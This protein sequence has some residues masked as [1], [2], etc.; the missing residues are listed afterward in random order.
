MRPQKSFQCSKKRKTSQAFKWKWKKLSAKLMRE[1][2]VH[3]H[4][5]TPYVH[6]L[7]NIKCLC[8]WLNWV[9]MSRVHR[10]GCQCVKCYVEFLQRRTIWK[11]LQ[12]FLHVKWT[13]I[14]STIS[15][16]V[17]L[18]FISVQLSLRLSCTTFLCKQ[19][20]ITRMG[21]NSLWM[22][23]IQGWPEY[24]SSG[25]LSPAAAR[26]RLWSCSPVRSQVAL[27]FANDHGL[28]VY[29]KTYICK[30]VTFCG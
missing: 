13:S 1:Y 11:Y 5:Q 30:M 3:L 12:S 23:N 16:K 21:D 2:L 6:I 29:H 10:Q 7:P 8:Q 27:K 4:G 19:E 15:I 24:P 20:T 26:R 18:T 28:Q 9:S 14:L 17:F 25:P 22:Y